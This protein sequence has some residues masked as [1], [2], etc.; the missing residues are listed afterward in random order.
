MAV[1]NIL[2]ELQMFAVLPILVTIGNGNVTK[3]STPITYL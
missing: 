3:Q 2:I 1:A